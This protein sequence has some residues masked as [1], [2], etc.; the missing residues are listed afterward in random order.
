MSLS[1]CEKCWDT[2]C[3]CGYEYREW[4]WE[5]IS[6]FFKTIVEAKVKYEKEKL[7]DI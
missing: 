6:E 2:P 5:K 3:Q 7:K 1:D 4:S